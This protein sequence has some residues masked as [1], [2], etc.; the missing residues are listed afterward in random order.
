MKN[1][2]E[3]PAD[4]ELL[5]RRFIENNDESAF[6]AL[7][8]KRLE[9]LRRIVAA[10]SG[11]GTLEDREDILQEVLIRLHQNL[12]GYRFE[13]SFTSYL[14]RITR[15]VALDMMR[16]RRRSRNREKRVVPDDSLEVFDPEETAL[17]RLRTEELRTLFFRLNEQDRQLLLLREREKLSMI[18][19]S[20]IL[21]IP[22]GTIKSRLSRARTRAKALY[23]ETHGKE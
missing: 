7:I 16:S 15:N 22:E 13:A 12:S 5:L 2:P 11:P 18:E 20:R 14:F 17:R 19:I 10:A 23:E 9:S 3:K 21:G 8:R 6:E 1:F 4:D